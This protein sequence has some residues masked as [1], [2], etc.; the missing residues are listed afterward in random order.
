MC[1]DDDEEEEEKDDQ[2]LSSGT[3]IETLMVQT[4]T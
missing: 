4:V 1:D 2:N 3:R